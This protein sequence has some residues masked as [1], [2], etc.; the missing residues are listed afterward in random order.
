MRETI[1]TEHD[2]QTAYSGVQSAPKDNEQKLYSLII[3]VSY[4]DLRGPTSLWERNKNVLFEF[5]VK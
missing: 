5:N 3:R 4:V 1:N 2:I